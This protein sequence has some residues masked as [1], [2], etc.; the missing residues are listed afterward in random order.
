LTYTV[1]GEARS[2]EGIKILGEHGAVVD[3]AYLP[4]LVQRLSARD[5]YF[6]KDRTSG[7]RIQELERLTEWRTQDANG[8]NVTLSGLKGVEAQRVSLGRHMAAL[9]AITQ[10]FK[11]SPM[12][13]LAQDKDGNIVWD[14]TALRHLST[15]SELAEIRAEQ[16]VRTHLS[17][18]AETIQQT[19]R[20]SQEDLATPTRLYGAVETHWLSK[21][22][23]LTPQDKQFLQSQ[24]PRYIRPATPEEAPTQGKTVVDGSFYDVI[25]DRAELRSSN[26]TQLQ[27][28]TSATTQAQKENG[29]RL[30]AAAAGKRPAL[31]PKVAP[32]T[33][34]APT[35]E[36]R[37]AQDAGDAWD[38][39]ESAAARM[40]RRSANSSA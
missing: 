3:K 33:P 5:H 7:Q 15:E 29:A 39:A 13:L 22:P 16:A 32:A 27:S 26:A 2:I 25:K 8:Q 35:Q 31:A 11:A 17:G 34:K 10:A 36:Q 18:L 14:Q 40:V 19:A 38:R 6:E 20:Q 37:R 28:V 4:T 30:A 1:N 9:S 21:H 12:Q 23:E 24:L